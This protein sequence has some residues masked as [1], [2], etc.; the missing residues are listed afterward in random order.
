LAC[1]LL[2]RHAVD[3]NVKLSPLFAGRFRRRSSPVSPSGPL[4]SFLSF[5]Y[6]LLS[7]AGR[8]TTFRREPQGALHK[9][10]CMVFGVVMAWLVALVVAGGVVPIADSIAS[11]VAAAV[12]SFIIVCV[13]R[14]LPFSNVP[15][16]FYGFASAFA[17]LLL[18]PRALQARTSLTASAGRRGPELFAARRGSFRSNVQGGAQGVTIAEFGFLICGGCHASTS[19]LAFRSQPGTTDAL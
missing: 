15:A 10:H 9:F 5:G 6:G 11:A 16:T 13:S 7:L 17:F 8:A 2:S 12:A 3:Q 18:V 1:P 4:R 14:Y 19:H